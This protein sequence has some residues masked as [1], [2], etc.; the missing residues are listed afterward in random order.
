MT[1][2]LIGTEES[3]L[4]FPAKVGRATLGDAYWYQD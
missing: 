2:G 3:C 1:S 4:G